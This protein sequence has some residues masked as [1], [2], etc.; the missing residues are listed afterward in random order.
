MVRRQTERSEMTF[1]LVRIGWPNIAAI[2]ALAVMP[3]VSLAMPA[4][5]RPHTA[6]ERGIKTAAFC[7]APPQVVMTM[8]ALT[9]ATV[10]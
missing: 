10:E 7:P 9:T 3:I 4:Q 1:E 5:Q 2:V 8:A 6:G